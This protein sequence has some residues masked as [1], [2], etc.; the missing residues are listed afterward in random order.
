M[1]PVTAVIPLKSLAMAK[2]RLA[3]ELDAATRREL[4][5][6]MFERVLRACERAR[7]V[8]DV[9]VVAGDE[10]A[11][12]VARA[13]GG[14]ALVEPHPGLARALAKADVATAGRPATLVVAADLP[15][16][17]AED[18]DAVC[19]AADRLS[20]SWRSPRDRP[21]R[22]DENRLRWR[23]GDSQVGPSVIVA[24]TRDG[25]TAAL[26]RRP[27]T[28]I[29]TAYGPGSAD[30]HVALAAAAGV[31]VLRLDLPRLA[32]DVD[33]PDALRE[34]TGQHRGP[35]RSC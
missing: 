17:T 5:A 32:L 1:Q 6:W 20:S 31:P 12:A 13:A 29:A 9:L 7:C 2:R 23:S 8:Q 19:A 3:A 4:V 16:A 34:V 26:L 10:E 33:T 30:A 35:L 25:G 28:V 11:A 14:V 15:L 18:I 22:T 27:P 21:T 24:A